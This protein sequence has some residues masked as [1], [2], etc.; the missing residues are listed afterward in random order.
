[1]FRPS[2]RSSS[3]FT[4]TSDLDMWDTKSRLRAQTSAWCGMA[5][6]SG[7][8]FLSKVSTNT[9][10]SAGGFRQTDPS[11]RKWQSL[12]HLVSEGATR[13]FPPSPGAELRASRCEGN[14]RQAGGVQWLR[15]AHKHL[16]TQLEQL[17]TRNSQLNTNI[18]AAQ[19]LDMKHKDNECE[20]GRQRGELHEKVLQLEKDLIQMRCALKRGSS[21]PSNET[22]PMTHEVFHRQVCNLRSCL[23]E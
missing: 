17:R 18:T 23:R 12:S 5:H 4:L 21:D 11:L 19:L 22:L 2:Y 10:G 1:M 15:D 9:S 13:T 7:T 3:P 14:V 20:K 8:E 6:V 16:D